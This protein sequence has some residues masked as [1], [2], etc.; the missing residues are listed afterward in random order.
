MAF[1][2]MFAFLIVA[3]FF[4]V[5]F[6]A[7]LW[8]FDHRTAQNQA[9]AAALAAV[10]HLPS[11]DTTAAAAA[12]AEWLSKNGSGPDDRSCLEFSDANGDGRFETVRVCVRRASPSIFASLSGITVATISASATATIGAVDGATVMPWA[13]VP[14]D[15]DCDY[16][17]D[18]YSPQC[19]SGVE[20]QDCPWGL[21][22][23]LL[24]GFKSGGGGNTGIIDSCGNGASNYRDCIT[25]DGESAFFEAGGF[26]AVG[27][28]GGNLG[29]NTDRALTER[30]E[31]YNEDDFTD[32]DLEAL[33]DSVSGVVDGGAQAA[34]DQFVLGI[35]EADDVDCSFR[36]VLVP[37]LREMPPNGCGSCSLEVLGVATFAIAS[38]NRDN[39]KDAWGTESQVCTPQQ[40]G[41][42]PDD[43]FDCGTGDSLCGMPCPR[44]TFSNGS[45]A[46]ARTHSHRC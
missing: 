3:M 2:F 1:L 31:Y 32:C 42:E 5:S 22:P 26:V 12:A 28:Q 11:D 8:F 25:G 14:P 29:V 17:E 19:E 45:A 44:I 9:E 7:G 38:W 16:D 37:I 20:F 43:E 13:V 4:A 6:D 40:G 36:L 24:I 34:W 35:N 30:Q 15:P 33:P 18:C 27:L 46:V 41:Q 23:D 21:H 39:G 10:Q